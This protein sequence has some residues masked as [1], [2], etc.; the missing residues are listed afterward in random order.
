MNLPI[1]QPT[2]QKFNHAPSV[3]HRLDLGWGTQIAKKCPA[4]IRGLQ[5]SQGCVQVTLGKGFL[6]GADVTMAFHGVPM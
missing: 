4:F 6:P 3:R 2:L 5:R 1:G